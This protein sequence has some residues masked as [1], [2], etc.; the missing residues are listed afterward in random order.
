MY[1]LRC[2]VVEKSLEHTL[3][4]GSILLDLALFKSQK[5]MFFFWL[6]RDYDKE[7]IVWLFWI[8]SWFTALQ[9]S[10]WECFLSVYTKKIIRKA[11]WKCETLFT[12][13]T[14]NRF[15]KHK[16]WLSRQRNR[17]KVKFFWEDT[18]FFIPTLSNLI[19]SI[20]VGEG[21]RSSFFT[22]KSFKNV[23]NLSLKY[24]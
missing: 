8:C 5:I 24:Y 16:K 13:S 7:K 4:G 19:F 9:T 21:P 20:V 14:F 15:T 11:F 18:N 6:F 3:A 10:R 23:R 2:C 12:S 22:F 17:K 1:V